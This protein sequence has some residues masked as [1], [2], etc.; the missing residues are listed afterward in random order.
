M[1]QHPNFP[2][3]DKTSSEVQQK[4]RYTSGVIHA[5]ARVAGAAGGVLIAHS[6][7]PGGT[8]LAI[9]CAMELE[10]ASTKRRI[11]PGTLT[12]RSRDDI[13][14]LRHV[15]L[16]IVGRLFEFI[17]GRRG[18]R[19]RANVIGKPEVQSCPRLGHGNAVLGRLNARSVKSVHPGHAS[20]CALFGAGTNQEGCFMRETVSCI[21]RQASTHHLPS[22]QC[23]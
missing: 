23:R 19:I 16:L 22:H 20:W 13:R 1:R 12:P 8:P 21:A 9:V 4:D 2:N 5:E 17:L 15:E 18:V 6:I 10:L 11:S 7:L 3:K 14:A